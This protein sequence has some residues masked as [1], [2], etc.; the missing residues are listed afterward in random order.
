MNRYFKQKRR[1][2]GV[3]SISSAF[4]RFNNLLNLIY[5]GAEKDDNGK[6]HI[7]EKLFD[8]IETELDFNPPESDGKSKKDKLEAQK[9]RYRKRDT[10][11]FWK[12]MLDS[13]NCKDDVDAEKLLLHVFHKLDER[14]YYG[15][16]THCKYALET[17]HLAV[18]DVYGTK[19]VEILTPTW[20]AEH[21]K[22]PNTKKA[23]KGKTTG[24]KYKGKEAV[25]GE[26]GAVSVLVSASDFDSSD[27]CPF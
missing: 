27:L 3:L 6:Y 10:Y 4:N 22:K 14:Y 12:T 1:E 2:D 9:K 21:F 19:K 23:K 8:L 11:C 16:M 15:S 7:T 26:R 5:L 17:L 24:A 13:S 20:V 18:D 25:K